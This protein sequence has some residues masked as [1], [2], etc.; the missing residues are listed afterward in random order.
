MPRTEKACV[1][2]ISPYEEEE[3]GCLLLNRCKCCRTAEGVERMAQVDL[4]CEAI[5]PCNH[6]CLLGR[7]LAPT[8]WTPRTP[9]AM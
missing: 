7:V 8:A 3:G 5:R 6:G 1:M 9:T 4:D 2:S